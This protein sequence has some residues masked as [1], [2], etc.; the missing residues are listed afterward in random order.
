MDNYLANESLAEHL[1]NLSEEEKLCVFLKGI[2]ERQPEPD[3]IIVVCVG[4]D[5]S[6]GDA[7][8]PIVGSMLKEQGWRVIGT[9]EEPCDAYAVEAAAQEALNLQTLEAY[10]VIAIDACLGK[11]KSVGTYIA[12]AGPLQ[13]GAATGRRLP[14]IG[15]Y[16]IAAV[17][18][19]NGPKAYWT[20]QTTSLHFV[21]GLAK[22][23]AGAFGKAWPEVMVRRKMNMLNREVDEQ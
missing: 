5:R 10:T 13:P 8:G 23:V 16:S 2:A 19:V 21:L 3:R 11:P 6:T 22:G 14:F 15:D 7:F 9:L 20:L 4:S 1:G 18:N 17:V 12:S